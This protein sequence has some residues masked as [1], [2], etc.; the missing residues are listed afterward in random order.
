MDRLVP[1]N[2]I[3]IRNYEENHGA[4][5][6]SQ[7]GGLTHIKLSSSRATRAVY[8]KIVAQTVFGL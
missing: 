4:L 3:M 8:T 2:L 5:E 6:E 7:D 1:N